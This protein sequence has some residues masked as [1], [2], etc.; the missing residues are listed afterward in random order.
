MSRWGEFDDY[1]KEVY[2]PRHT[3]LSTRLCHFTGVAF[4]FWWVV[5]AV[6]A[7]SIWATVLMLLVAPFVVYPFAIPSHYI[8]EKNRPALFDG[9]PIYAK[10]SDFR[11]CFD[12]AIG[13]LP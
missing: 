12:L 3:K 9:H 4:T 5:V 2:L 6:L 7:S 1:Y 11:M 10:L 13:K 8:F